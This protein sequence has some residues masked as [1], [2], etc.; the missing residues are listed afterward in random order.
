MAKYSLDELALRI[1]A[2]EEKR[3]Q[4]GFPYAVD[5]GPEGDWNQASVTE[6]TNWNLTEN[7]MEDIES[8]LADY[9]AFETDV[10][11]N[12]ETN[13]EQCNDAVQRIKNG[14]CSKFNHLPHFL[15]E[16]Y[17]RK[18]FKE[19]FG[20]DQFDPD[21]PLP[22]LDDDMKQKLEDAG[23]TNRP[24]FRYMLT[25]LIERGAL[26][27]EG[28]LIAGQLLEYDQYLNQ[29]MLSRTLDPVD[30]QREQNILNK[31][32]GKEGEKMLRVNQEKQLLMA[33]TLFMTQLGRI[34][35]KSEVADDD[36]VTD[37]YEGNIV[38]LFSH[39]GRVMFT[40]PHG[41][42]SKQDK[43]FDAWQKRTLENEG[44]WE[45]RF[46]SHDIKRRH[47]NDYGEVTQPSKE[48]KLKWKEQLKKGQLN[49]KITT[50]F[51]NYGMN[52]PLGG[53]GQKFNGNDC[54]DGK[55][56]FGH[57]YVREKKG[58][59][60]ICGSILVGIENAAPKME[61]CVGQLHNYKAIGHDMSPFYSGK[62]APG[63]QYDGREVDLSHLK[64]EELTKALQDFEVGYAQ[65]QREAKTDPPSKQKLKEINE[66]LCGKYMNAM[67]LSNLM[68]SVGMKKEEAIHL[69]EAGRSPKHAN[70]IIHIGGPDVYR[71]DM[72]KVLEP[73]KVKELSQN[74]ASINRMQQVAGNAEY[75]DELRRQWNSMA[76]H[77]G[78]SIFNSSEFKKMEKAFGRYLKAYDNIMSGKTA[79]GKELRANAKGLSEFE[80][81]KLKKYEKEMITA[82]KEYHNAKTLQK[83]G[84]FEKHKTDQARDRDAMSMALSDF[85]NGAKKF[86]EEKQ[87]NVQTKNLSEKEKNA[88]A[89]KNLDKKVQELQKSARKL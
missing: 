11:E 51:G 2:R 67:E 77:T 41:E 36:K 37:P 80:L 54:V 3:K 57:M 63:A 44:M 17:G 69:T 42:S 84:G 52:I 26:D 21:N 74:E 82:A 31:F 75:V 24:E 59:K 14:D 16:Y 58:D 1:M 79:E 38:E 87:K 50:Y 66:K 27:S 56:S 64:P 12:K 13:R 40:L 85:E 76:S 33:K 48:I 32:P 43:M 61:S 89:R 60:N 8:A 78:F 72:H 53:L 15:R 7:D 10:V 68:T 34:D 18:A 70:Y 65:L 45:G 25:Q 62:A 88:R 30:E 81:G 9:G 39:S 23:M 71:E 19:F 4:S 83:N 73:E 20:T 22:P 47:V 49:K 5:E 28:K 29:R 35:I 6:K 86:S 46:A 55:G